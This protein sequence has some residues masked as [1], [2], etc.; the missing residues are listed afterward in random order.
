MTKVTKTEI[1]NEVYDLIL[2]ANVTQDERAILVNFKNRVTDKNFANELMGLAA[3]LRQ[4]GIK[5]LAAQKKMSPET[6]AFYKKIATYGQQELNW[7]R[8]L[9]MT[10]VIF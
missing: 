4:L 10:G 2:N 5:N 7:A 1:M 8:G 3:G 9:A 6:S